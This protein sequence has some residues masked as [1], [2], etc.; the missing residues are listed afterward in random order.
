[1]NDGNARGIEATLRR[2][3]EI[4]L[5]LND[6]R[7][8]VGC[9]GAVSYL[10]DIYDEQYLDAEGRKLMERLQGLYRDQLE[11]RTLLPP[12]SSPWI[13]SSAS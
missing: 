12:G 6:L 2:P 13:R 8:I 3:V 10:S 5:S 4:D 11:N 7:I 9:I 1:M